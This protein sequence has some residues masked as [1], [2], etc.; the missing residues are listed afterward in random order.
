MT[1]TKIIPKSNVKSVYV[2]FTNAV[3]LQIYSLSSFILV[4]NTGLR[5]H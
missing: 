5:Y 1:L 2:A 4:S 3:E